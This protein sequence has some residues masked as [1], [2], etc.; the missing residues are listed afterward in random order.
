LAN[1]QV[2]HAPISEDVG[3]IRI[4]ADLRLLG[5]YGD[6][7]TMAL[8]LQ[9]YLPS[10]RRDTYT[11]DETLRVHPRLLAA[12]EVGPFVYAARVSIDVRTFDASYAGTQLGSE[13]LFGASAGVKVLD[14]KLVAG[15]EIYG[16]TVI[17]SDEGPFNTHNT[18]YEIM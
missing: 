13:L 14:K 17:D 15:P 9:L 5:E 2:Y 6:P 3:D 11:G 12:G 4:G 1:N 8:G 10:G 18:P 16:S 7:F